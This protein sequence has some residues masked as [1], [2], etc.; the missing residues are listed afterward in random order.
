MPRFAVHPDH[1]HAALEERCERV[2]KSRSTVLFRRGEKA[3]G[4]FL[5][6]RGTVSLDFGVDSSA[7]LASAYGPGA[8]VGLPA[9]LTGRNYSMTA[10][11][12]D[13]AELGFLTSLAVNSLL[14]QRPDLC[15]QLLTILGEKISQ[16]RQIT[17]ALLN[18]ETP[19][20]Q[21]ANVV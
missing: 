15:Q 7:K 12:T 3:F 6:L 9:T 1:L 19:P 13:D 4:M 8:L 11:V 2:R 17:R 10:T 20:S 21:G 18:N 14:R 5:V 16:T